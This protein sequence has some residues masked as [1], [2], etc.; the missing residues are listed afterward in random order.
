MNFSIETTAEQVADTFAS[1]ITGK[2]GLFGSF[3]VPALTIVVLVTGT[4]LNGIGFETVRVLAKHANLV[5]ITGYNKERLQL[6]EEAIKKELPSANIRQLRLDLS[7]LAAVRTAAAEVNAYPEPL[8]VLI[9]NAVGTILPFAVSVDGFEKQMA[10]GFIGPFLFTNLIAP[11][12]LAS[13]TSHSGYTPRVVFLSSCFH[14]V[15]S[16]VDFETFGLPMPEKYK[17]VFEPYYEVKSAAILA[18]IELG[19]RTEGRIVGYSVDPGVISTNINQKEENR[20][21]F[22]EAGIVDEHGKPNLELGL[23][24]WKTMGQGA[25]TTVRAAFDPSLLAQPGAYL[26]D[27]Q[28][29]N[30]Q[31]APHSSNPENAKKLW[32]ITETL[33]GQ[34]FRF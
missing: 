24:T 2:N 17:A 16:G 21:Y 11:K 27:C 33:L 32:D 8:H 19:K 31:V 9:N 1:E 25:A 5:I 3:S 18:A 4:S 12:L 20:V 30:E 26:A 14:A 6:T 10:T 28:V 13:R 22:Q 34:E 29:A 7:S 15:G 23:F